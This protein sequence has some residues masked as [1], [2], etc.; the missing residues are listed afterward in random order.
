V[1]GRSSLF[2]Y[3][4]HVEMV[5]GF[6]SRPLHRSLSLGGS[7]VACAA[8]AGF[9]YGLVVLKNRFVTRSRQTRK[10]VAERLA[11]T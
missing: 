1:F 2:V 11:Q 4:I 10:P 5:Y 6:V 7:L 3:W 8:F 9:L